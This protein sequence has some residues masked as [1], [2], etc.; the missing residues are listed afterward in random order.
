MSPRRVVPA[1]LLT[2]LMA[3]TACGGAGETNTGTDSGS[4]TSADGAFPV[5]IEHKYGETTVPEEPERVVTLGLSDQDAAL[6]LGVTPVGAVDWFLEEPYGSWPWTEEL[7]GDTPPEVVGE[8]DEYNMER[9]AALE[10]DL[11]IAQYSGMQEEQYETLSQIAPVVAQPADHPDYAAPWQEMS[12]RIGQALGREDEMRARIDDV[13]ASFAQVREDHPEFAEE[14]AI[15]ADSFEPGAYFA[16]A[17]TDPKAIFFAEMGFQLSE[18]VDALVEDGMNGAE[19]GSERLDV[20][21]SADRVIWVTSGDEADARIQDEPLYQRL[22]V[23]DSEG[24]VFVPYQDAETGAAIGAAFSFNTVLSISYA[25]DE[26][27]PL[28]T[29]AA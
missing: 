6:A 17:D 26:M 4:G 21:D 15:V 12:L 2:L 20:L 11:I 27:T 24:T 10:P 22:D 1:A 16:F 9:I 18:E 7:W 25:I 14:T 19:F 13:E 29:G 3:L 23:A 28:L 8:R 5:T